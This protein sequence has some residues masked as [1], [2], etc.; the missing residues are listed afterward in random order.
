MPRRADG[1]GLH[2]IKILH[3]NQSKALKFSTK[4]KSRGRAA[5]FLKPPA[6]KAPGDGKIVRH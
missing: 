2:I 5:L 1:F 3:S 4:R 6:L